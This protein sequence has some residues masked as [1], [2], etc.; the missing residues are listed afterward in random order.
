MS[1]QIIFLKNNHLI[2]GENI[3]LKSTD[4][5]FSHQNILDIR[6]R[7]S[8]R[9][10]KRG[11][12]WRRDWRDKEP[13]SV[14][15]NDLHSTPATIETSYAELNGG[16]NDLPCENNQNAFARI[17][18]DEVVCRRFEIRWRVRD[19]NIVLDDILDP[20]RKPAK[21]FDSK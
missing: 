2:H 1:C 11:L 8:M 15:Q 16:F 7:P 13:T 10:M 20:F 9:I 17:L 4:F 19:R 18:T 14:F 21:L 12:R 6:S 5:L 3:L